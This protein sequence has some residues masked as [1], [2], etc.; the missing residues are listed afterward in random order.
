MTERKLFRV[1]IGRSLWY[2]EDYQTH[3]VEAESHEQAAAIANILFNDQTHIKASALHVPFAAVKSTAGGTATT[4][5][6]GDGEQEFSF[7]NHKAY[8]IMYR[9]GA[10]VWPA[11]LG[12]VAGILTLLFYGGNF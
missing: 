5:F 12:F 9:V 1:K 4:T 11:G 3:Y 10:N 7:T 2:P 8:A 6:E